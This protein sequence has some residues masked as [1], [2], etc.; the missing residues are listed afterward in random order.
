VSPGQIWAQ[1]AHVALK[2]ADAAERVVSKLQRSRAPERA[3]AWRHEAGRLQS[4]AFVLFCRAR[5]EG[6]PHVDRAIVFSR[7]L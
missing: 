2:D 3:A 6:Y 1:L 5:D 7:R 4:L